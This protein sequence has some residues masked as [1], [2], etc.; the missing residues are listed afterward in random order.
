MELPQPPKSVC[1][2]A[3]AVLDG[4][5]GTEVGMAPPSTVDQGARSWGWNRDTRKRAGPRR[6]AGAGGS[7]VT[8]LEGLELGF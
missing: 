2:G 8:G 6:P 5:E 7:Q 3:E 1:P 4:A